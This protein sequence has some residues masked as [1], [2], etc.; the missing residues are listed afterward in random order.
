VTNCF[1]CHGTNTTAVSH[2]FDKFQPL[3]K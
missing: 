3:F 2:A 1:T